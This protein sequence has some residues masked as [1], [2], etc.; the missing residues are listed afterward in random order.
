MRTDGNYGRTISYEPNSFGEWAD[1][2]KLKEP[3]L[4]GGPAY[5]YD[6]REYDCDYFTQPGMLWRLMSKE[7]QKITCENTARAMGDAEVFIKQ[8]HIRNCYK[9]DPDYGAGV[10]SALGLDLDEALNSSDPAERHDFYY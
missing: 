8:R 6:E 10:A 5:N 7:D 2:P 3:P 4:D 1:S 9:A